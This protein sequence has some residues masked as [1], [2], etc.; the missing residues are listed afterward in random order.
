MV[1]R[2][3]NP[4]GNYR[5]LYGAVLLPYTLIS[6]GVFALTGSGAAF[7]TPLPASPELLDGVLSQFITFL[8]AGC[9]WLVSYLPTVRGFREVRDLELA[10]STAISMLR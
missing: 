3:R 8:A 10:T 7:L 9:I 2:L 1:R 5:L 6:Y 4:V